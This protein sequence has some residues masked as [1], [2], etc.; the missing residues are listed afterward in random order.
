MRQNASGAHSAASVGSSGKQDF[1]RLQPR[2]FGA[3]RGFVR[4]LFDA[5]PAAREFEPC[6]AEA[7][8]GAADA[9]EAAVAGRIEQRF[10]GERARA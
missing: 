8:V 7:A 1:G 6:D 9:G 10:F 4:D 2:E 5:E 3:Q